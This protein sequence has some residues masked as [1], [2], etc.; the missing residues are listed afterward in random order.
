MR[1]QPWSLLSALALIAAGFTSA[2]FGENSEYFNEVYNPDGTPRPG[3]AEILP[4]YK[5]LTPRQHLDFA[6]V[7]R[8]DFRGDN[9]L[10][11]MPRILTESELST[12]Q[13]GVEQ[14]GKAIQA[15]LKD[16]FSG[17]K[18]IEKLIPQ[19]V[20]DRIVA[21]SQDTAW[22]GQVDPKQI[23]FPYGPDIIRDAQGSWRV[24]EDNPGFIGGPGDLVL[25]RESLM[26][27][28][29]DYKQALSPV[30]DPLD[31]YRE[32]VKRYSSLRNPSDGRIVL[33]SVP[34]YP[35]REDRRL[36]RIFH[37]LGV[38]IVGPTTAKRII[39]DESGVWVTDSTDPK[40]KRQ[41]VGFVIINSEHS[42]MDPTHPAA[43]ERALVEEARGHLS[44]RGQ[45]AVAKAKLNKALTPDPKTGK[46]NLQAIRDALSQSEVQNSMS[47]YKKLAA[48]GLNEAILKGKV[49]ANY[50]PGLDFIG[51][52][53]FYVYV[54]DMVRHY[55][56]EEPVLKNLPTERFGTM[57]ANGSVSLNRELVEKVFS[58]PSRYVVKAVDGRGG[59]A[60]WVGAKI[61]PE[62][63]KEA[64]A[65]IE[66]DPARFIV[67]EYTH[68]SVAGDKIVDLRMISAVDPKGVYVSGTP[69][70]RALPLDGDGKVNLSSSGREM[71]VLV[72]KDPKKNCFTQALTNSLAR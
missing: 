52:K 10:D 45:S 11:A 54:D 34:P 43:Y 27:R 40:A 44:E 50:T 42:F 39:N 20:L 9:A 22:K 26:R 55:L 16:Y 64:K 3:Y 62:K 4:Y 48:K 56:K 59:D 32:L 36:K 66:A 12:L 72:V 21:R 14:R 51:D 37:D 41:R 70:A 24:I 61:S 29:P 35:D 47:Y 23:S 8:K 19:S 31:F 69:W 63:F 2:A 53:E 17:N 60:V 28:M 15:F 18:E 38:D 49:A 65:Q 67:Q 5:K 6:K 13:K 58:N 25:A 33:Y 68:L 46:L 7:T 30:N 71:T 1:S 57:N